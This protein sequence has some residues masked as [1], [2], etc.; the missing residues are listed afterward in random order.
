MPN[1]LDSEGVK[2]SAPV[3]TEQA[4]RTPDLNMAGR[5][6]FAF[7]SNGTFWAAWHSTLPSCPLHGPVFQPFL[8]PSTP[9]TSGTCLT[10]HLTHTFFINH[11]F[12]LNMKQ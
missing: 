6:G 11:A 3:W 1:L 4:D 12:S 8:N 10:I 7:P 5:G 9:G 2:R